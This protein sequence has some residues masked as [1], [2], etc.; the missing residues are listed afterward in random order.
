MAI[1][2]VAVK[3]EKSGSAAARRMRVAGR[4]PGVIYNRTGTV[5]QVELHLHHASENL[6]VD[7]QLDGA[8]LGKALLKDVQHHPITGHVLHVDFLEIS[9]TE[10]L[11]LSIPVELVGES[12]GVLDQGGILEHVLRE[13]EVECLPGDLVEVFKVP[14][15]ALKLNE[16]LLVRDLNLGAAYTVLT[17]GA[18]AVALVTEPKE[19][20]APAEAAAAAG[21]AAEPEVIRKGKEDAEGAE[22]P[23]K[24]GGKEKAPAAGGKEKAA[25][26][27]KEKSGG[28]D[29]GG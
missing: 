7:V 27:G 4:L 19:E 16:S 26:G 12:T 21:A 1:E 15:T 10:K 13:I 8:P 11:R 6:I 14:V 5:H 22:E 25:G 23:A 29:K 17:S 24:G 9:M 2:I 20:E 3:R 18:L 28:K